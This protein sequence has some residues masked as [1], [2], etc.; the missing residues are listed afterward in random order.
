MQGGPT[1]WICPDCAEAFKPAAPAP[2][3]APALP[4]YLLELVISGPFPLAREQFELFR[5]RDPKR[6]REALGELVTRL[7]GAWAGYLRAHGLALPKRRRRR[8][9]RRRSRARARGEGHQHAE[10]RSEIR[11]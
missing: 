7:D 1:D 9:R 2:A 3:P 4:A 5:E 11:A 8:R 10:Y 6:H